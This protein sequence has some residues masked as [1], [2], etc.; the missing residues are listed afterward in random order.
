ME[1][2]IVSRLEGREDKVVST[3]NSL[4]E[5]VRLQEALFLVNPGPHS[6]HIVYDDLTEKTLEALKPNDTSEGIEED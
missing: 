1:Y 5:A 2:K 6:Y 4:W 3:L